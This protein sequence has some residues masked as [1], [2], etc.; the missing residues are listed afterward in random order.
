[1]ASWV[2]VKEDSDFSLRNLPYGVF[3]ISGS[4]PPRIGT[5]IGDYVLDMN[6]LAVD[7]VFEDIGFDVATLGETTLNSYAA[8][9]KDVHSKVRERVQ[10]LLEK[11]TKLGSLLRDNQDRR[12]RALVPMSSVQMHLPMIIGDYTDFFIGLHHA[13]TVSFVRNN[14]VTFMLSESMADK[15]SLG[16]HPVRECPQTRS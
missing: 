11:E 9:G 1:M 12:A 3:S 15:F 14:H 6:V 8:L 2:E 5:A 13:V 10:G 4:K 16:G 7:G